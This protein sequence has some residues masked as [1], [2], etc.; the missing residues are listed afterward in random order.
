M[1]VIKEYDESTLGLE[2]LVAYQRDGNKPN[3]AAKTPIPKTPRTP[4]Q[5]SVQFR[6]I[7]LKSNQFSATTTTPHANPFSNYESYN[8]DDE[9]EDFDN[10][11]ERKSQTPMHTG[12]STYHPRLASQFYK[13]FSV[14]VYNGVTGT[15]HRR[16]TWAAPRTP[17]RTPMSSYQRSRVATPHNPPPPSPHEPIFKPEE[18]TYQ[19]YQLDLEPLDAPEDGP[20]FANPWLREVA[21]LSWRTALNVVRTPELFL[22]REIVLTVM[23]LI[24][25]TLFHRL[26][27]ASF[28]TINRILNFYIFAVCLVF[29]SSNDAVPTFIQE[30]FIFIRERSHNAYRASSYV[31]S[32]L[33]VYL[34]FFAIQGF[35]FAVITKFMLHLKS[36]LVNFWIIL[37]HHS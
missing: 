21:V 27:D 4:Y 22:S 9:E 24:L 5:K 15:P 16:P 34:P 25:S 36:S 35:T 2:P 37:L 10:S 1:D 30:R 8:I 11:L 3:E 6:Q 13:D 33:I 17:S 31:I 18:P 12:T 28:A 20:K 14:W 23:A 7:Q 26:S 32:S 29:F 19:E